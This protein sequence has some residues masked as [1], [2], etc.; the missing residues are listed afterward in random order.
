MLFLLG[1]VVAI[2]FFWSKESKEIEDL[3]DWN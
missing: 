2:L 3:S 1:I